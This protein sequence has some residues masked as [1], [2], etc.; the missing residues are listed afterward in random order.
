MTW[1]ISEG[2]DVGKESSLLYQHPITP[3]KG[4]ADSTVTETGHFTAI[5]RL[6]AAGFRVNVD[7]ARLA[8]SPAAL[9]TTE[10][11]DWLALNKA[12]LV[13]A[14]V[15][16]HG[17]WCVEYPRAAVAAD[18]RT[19]CVAVYLPATDWRRVSADYPGAAVWPAPDGFDVAGWIDAGMPS[20]RPPEAASA[21]R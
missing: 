8:V 16:E 13:A 6:A 10:Q 17:H 9:L 11:R 3:T 1:R 19:R 15:A 2:G 14:L 20:V 18:S 21:T 5:N 7:G 12:A 4:V